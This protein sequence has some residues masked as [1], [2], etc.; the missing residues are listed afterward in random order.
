MSV[1]AG[2]V[3]YCGIYCGDCLG[4]TGVIA[5]AAEEFLDVLDKYKF[6][7]TAKYVFPERLGDYDRL[8]DMLLFMTEMKCY[9]T[10]RERNDEEASC[11]VRNCCKTRGFYACHECNDFEQCE[12]LR[13]VLGGLHLDVC[14]KNLREMR[15]MGLEA[16][17]R[18][19]TK[20]HYWDEDLP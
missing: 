9:K 12:T 3:T 4:Y 10:C 11:V 14:L 16:W 7:M 19:G 2:L 5:D 6:Y 13:S 17:L 8:I 20:H 15:E 18:D 1:D